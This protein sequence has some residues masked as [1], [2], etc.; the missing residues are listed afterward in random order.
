VKLLRGMADLVDTPAD[1][2][3]L[4]V[5]GAEV[6]NRLA[7]VMPSNRRVVAGGPGFDFS[8][9]KGRKVVAA[10]DEL[11]QFAADAGAAT[12]AV[13]TDD[14]AGALDSADP[15]EWIRGNMRLY[16]AAP[17]AQS[18]PVA[19][20]VPVATPAPAQKPASTKATKAPKLDKIQINEKQPLKTA[21]ELVRAKY[22][23]GNLPTIIR[24]CGEWFTWNGRCYLEADAEDIREKTYDFMSNCWVWSTKASD[25][26]P[27]DPNPKTVS[28]VVDALRAV[29]NEP[30]T[31]QPPVWLGD[32]VPDACP[33]PAEILVCAN[34]ILHLPTLHLYPLTPLLFCRHAVDYSYDPDAPEPVEWLRFLDQ[35]WPDDPESILSLQMH[36]GYFLTQDTSQQKI[37]LLIGPKR[38]GK[39]TI[40]RVAT[41]M[42]GAGNVCSPTL[43]SLATNF[44][45]QPLI[46]K[47][48]AIIADARLSGKADHAVIA[49]RLLSI[50]GEDSLTIDRKFMDGW[51][52]KLSTRIMILSNELPKLNDASGA[53]ASRFNIL[54]IKPSFFGQE[55]HG[56][57]SRLLPEL[58]G[59]LK[60]S[61]EGWKAL[62][63][64]GY[65]LVP[66]SSRQASMQ[67]ADLS[68]PMG[69]FLR[70]RCVIGPD[71]H[72]VISDLFEVWRQWCEGAGYRHG[73]EP[74]FGRD[75]RSCVPSVELKRP[76]NALGEQRRTYFGVGLRSHQSSDG[77]DD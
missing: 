15:V 65:L 41:A 33:D 25:L 38:C 73:T 5:G 49:E 6:R 29:A 44:G 36:F 40:A 28:D 21:K 2:P 54:T 57:L 31:I 34:G 64:R 77:D 13:L 32:H 51:T 52:G 14:V 24:H 20:P 68:S 50:S 22:N 8:P 19:T 26:V 42:L 7:K 11:A 62:Q 74:S 75:L 53:L 23:V 35:L 48:L 45:L 39:G 18:A 46:N 60:W 9:L 37:P 70:Q 3:V 72:V 66:Q 43:S 67:L 47:T 76:R 16:E 17:V 71:E 58:P 61:I 4:L 10:F 69:A 63:E 55:D 1:T 59:I 12:V 30:S 56:L 27:C